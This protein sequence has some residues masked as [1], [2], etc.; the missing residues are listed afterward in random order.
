MLLT[1]PLGLALSRIQRIDIRS[2]LF[3]DRVSLEFKRLGQESVAILGLHAEGLEQNSKGLG[4]LKGPL[5]RKALRELPRDLDAH[6][7]LHVESGTV[8]TEYQ[9]IACRALRRGMLAELGIYELGIDRQGP[10]Y[11]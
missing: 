2:I 8:C 4:S 6:V 11:R 1:S 3:G 9:N 5:A 10:V 7:I